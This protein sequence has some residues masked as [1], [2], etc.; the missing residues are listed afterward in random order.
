[1]PAASDG[2]RLALV[3]RL[4][5]RLGHEMVGLVPQPEVGG[6]LGLI[7]LEHVT[8]A[9]QRVFVH[10]SGGEHRVEND[11]LPAVQR[12]ASFARRQRQG[13]RRG[14][15]FCLAGR[16]CANLAL[17][18][19]DRQTRAAVEVVHRLR[20]AI[21]VPLGLRA[22]EVG[23]PARSHVVQVEEDGRQ[24]VLGAVL[25]RGEHLGVARVGRRVEEV[26]VR[27]VVLEVLVLEDLA[28][29]WGVSDRA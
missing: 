24:P 29:D 14:N 3:R 10:V 21:G 18:R 28:A 4:L 2:L 7:I 6:P 20:P 5:A 17:L 15:P 27:R 16:A 11:H 22:G 9:V 1:M 19:V 26:V 8:S 12:P 13:L 23:L 25:H